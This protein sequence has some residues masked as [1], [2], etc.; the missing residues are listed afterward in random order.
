MQLEASRR[1]RAADLLPARYRALLPA[2]GLQRKAS[3]L[4]VAIRANQMLL[5]AVADEQEEAGFGVQYREGPPSSEDGALRP[6]APLGAMATG[7]SAC[8]H[9]HDD[10]SAHHG[11]VPHGAAAPVP[12]PLPTYVPR[13]SAANYSKVKSTLH[14]LVRDWGEEGAAERASCYGPVLRELAALLP[15]TAATANRQRVLVPG[16]GLGRLVYELALAGYAAQGNEFSYQMLFVS[17]L[18]RAWACVGELWTMGCRRCLEMGPSLLLS[19]D[20]PLSPSVWRWAPLSFCLEIGPSLLLSGDW[21]LSPCRGAVNTTEAAGQWQVHPWIHDPSNHLRPD[22]MLRAVR[23]PDC[24][25]SALAERNPG[26]D[27]SMTAGE[28]AECYGTPEHSGAW[29]AV[30]TVFFV[31]TAPVVM[32]CEWV[33]CHGEPVGCA[34]PPALSSHASDFDV[35]W[36]ALRPGGYWINL[37]PLLYHW[38]GGGGAADDA[39]ADDS[40]GADLRYLQSLEL[41]YQEVRFALLA[42]GFE[43]V[44][45]AAGAKT[46]YAANRLSLLAN[47]YSPLLWVVRKPVD[48]GFDGGASAGTRS[49][50]H[51]PSNA[52]GRAGEPQPEAGTAPVVGP[53]SEE[54]ELSARVGGPRGGS[55]AKKRGGGGGKAGK[56]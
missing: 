13:R 8:S 12:A 5:D 55:S 26:A 22:D 17:H 30:T 35:V 40:D 18:I 46:T 42:R 28:F 50:A 34:R 45:E 15:V 48:S 53:M 52:S 6:L 25:P 3:L 39:G 9:S 41:S 54:P 4:Q 31:D 27:M 11:S 33:R 10:A 56:H 2:G 44:R 37:G 20:G 1:Q 51:S 36:H 38:Q 14:Q 47:V 23:V 16:C 24:A 7:G 43:L 32:E 21:P 29:D 19:G 49:S